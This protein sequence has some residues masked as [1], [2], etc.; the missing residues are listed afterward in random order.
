MFNPTNPPTIL[1]PL[2]KDA[3]VPKTLT[4]TK[5]VLIAIP[6]KAPTYLAAEVILST[7]KLILRIVDFLKFYMLK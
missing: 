7:L 3:P 6:A 5:L 1:S 4:S 2:T